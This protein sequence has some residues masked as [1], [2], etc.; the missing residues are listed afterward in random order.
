MN[1]YNV[2]LCRYAKSVRE[3]APAMRAAA[4]WFAGVYTYSET[5]TALLAQGIVQVPEFLARA[6][7][8]IRAAIERGEGQVA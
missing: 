4:M 2:Q 1:S 6:E 7:G 8:N 3:S 5:V